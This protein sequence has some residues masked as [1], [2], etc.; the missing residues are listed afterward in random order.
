MPLNKA[1]DHVRLAEVS[2]LER[3]EH[4]VIDFGHHDEPTI[5]AGAELRDP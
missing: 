2:L 5:G 4:L 1:A 3:D